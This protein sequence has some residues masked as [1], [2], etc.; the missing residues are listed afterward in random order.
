MISTLGPERQDLASINVRNFYTLTSS[1]YNKTLIGKK[2][3][4]K[5]RSTKWIF[6]RKTLD[7][8]GPNKNQYHFLAPTNH[9]DKFITQN[10]IPKPLQSKDQNNNEN[11][12]TSNKVT[13][14]TQ[15]T[16]LEMTIFTICSYLVP[17]IIHS[18]QTTGVSGLI[19]IQK[20]KKIIENPPL[21]CSY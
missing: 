3:S 20:Q 21:K 17:T 1:Q 16:N 19:A 9:A 6:N 8:P 15:D 4:R 2:K 13:F 14:F 18:F 11:L 5:K 12:C 10:L 7:R